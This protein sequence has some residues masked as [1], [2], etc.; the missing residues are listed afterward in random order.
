MSVKLKKNRQSHSLC[1]AN[2]R[3]RCHPLTMF[4]KDIEKCERKQR[5][6]MEKKFCINL[7]ACKC[8]LMLKGGGRI[9]FAQTKMRINFVSIIWMPVTFLF[10][11]IYVQIKKFAILSGFF[12][13]CDTW[14]WTNKKSGI[15][16][17]RI[18]FI[19]FN[20]CIHLKCGATMSRVVR[21]WLRAANVS[22]D[23]WRTF[24]TKNPFNF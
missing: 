7:N 2:Q 18:V 11:L 23:K 4:N 17:H 1:E 16:T 22:K 5:E 15:M 9:T 13:V 21:Q 14:D 3:H 12:C 19:I 20:R 10:L 8:R 6:R 24:N